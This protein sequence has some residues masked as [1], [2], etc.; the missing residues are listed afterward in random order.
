MQV[1]CALV[2]TEM[3]R[4]ARKML[5][6]HRALG[7][8]VRMLVHRL[9]RS[10]DMAAKC[11]EMLDF[12]A[13]S[14]K[15]IRV[16]GSDKNFS[17]LRE[18][19]AGLVLTRS[20]R[21]ISLS[22]DDLGA[23]EL[24][25]ILN[26]LL[27]EDEMR[28]CVLCR[29]S[30]RDRLLELVGLLI[31]NVERMVD[32]VKQAK[33]ERE[34]EKERARLREQE[35]ELGQEHPNLAPVP[36]DTETASPASERAEPPAAE[37]AHGVGDGGGGGGDGG[38][39]S[40]VA[41]EGDSGAGAGGGTE[42]GDAGAGRG[43]GSTSA[44]ASA[45]SASKAQDGSKA[46]EKLER[47]AAKKRHIS[48][49]VSKRLLAV[50]RLL[51]RLARDDARPLAAALCEKFGNTEQNRDKL[52]LSL[53]QLIDSGLL[54]PPCDDEDRADRKWYSQTVA[55]LTEDGREELT[56]YMSKG[57]HA[58]SS[59]ELQQALADLQ[60]TQMEVAE[61]SMS[62]VGGDPKDIS[63]V[64]SVIRDGKCVAIQGEEAQRF[65]TQGDKHLKWVR[66][67]GGGTEPAPFVLL[68]R[69]AY[70][71]RKYVKLSVDSTQICT[72][73]H[74]P[75]KA[76]C[77]D[78]ACLLRAEHVEC[79]P[80]F[81]PCGE[82]CQNQRF[83]RCQNAPVKVAYAGKKKGWGLFA[84]A[85]IECGAFIVEYMGEVCGCGGG[86]VGVGVGMSVWVRVRVRLWVGVDVGIGVVW[87]W[88]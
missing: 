25:H 57:V 2:T 85:D 64:L 71:H 65:V 1:R 35:R 26:Q 62:L 79:T 34:R 75:G 49:R 58:A 39:G 74:R 14:R 83:Q 5:V 44:S 19:A 3:Q 33:N 68:R 66:R 82:D 31:K 24:Q 86:G 80:G 38:G 30:V 70:V 61:D 48:S 77:H 11:I 29:V 28:A 9:Q 17:E 46:Q 56:R 41:G 23:L 87:V 20:V 12:L 84:A 53:M 21:L 45:S 10:D 51:A 47:V 13:F 7:L 4:E 76:C 8:V 88:V 6:K 16:L 73:V 60:Q 67:T 36:A 37:E 78:T 63:E 22:E 69:N 54:P 27:F 43:G 55:L 81:C 15:F 50:F 72:C 32:T 42:G 18:S 40:S 59:K 52:I